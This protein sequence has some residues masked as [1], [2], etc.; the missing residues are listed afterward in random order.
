MTGRAVG[1]LLAP[2]VIL[3]E[4]SRVQ[5]PGTVLSDLFN[6]GLPARNPDAQT[7]NM[8]SYDLREGSYDVFNRS[9]E[10]AHGSV[11]GSPNTMIKPQKVGRVRFTI[12]RSAESLPM[13]DEDLVN[14]RQVGQAVTSVDSMGENYIMRQKQYMASRVGNMIEFQTAAL[15]RGSYTFDQ[16]GDELRQGFSGGEQTIDFQIPSG[17]KNQLDMLGAGAIIGASWATTSTDIPLDCMQVNDAM[18][19]LTGM[20]IEH[21]ILNSTTLQYLLNNTKIQAQAGTSNTPYQSYSQTGPGRFAVVFR[22]IPWLQFHVIDYRLDIWDGSAVTNTKL[23]AD[24]QVTF[25]PTPNS[26]WVQYLNG[27]EVITEGPN[28]TRA[29]RNGYYAYGY[30]TWNP[31][32]WMLNQAHNGFPALYVPAAIAN[33]D[34]T[35]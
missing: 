26:N 20:G 8:V 19:S 31:S 12:P 6:W 33:A 18:N 7:G 28:G 5:L 4:V 15:M 24:D 29:F 34:V 1:D 17:N 35:P 16:N 2:E 9:K 14:R 22:A 3:R 27:G 11:P 23:V 10:L 25:M 13:T 30:Q 32:G 21:A